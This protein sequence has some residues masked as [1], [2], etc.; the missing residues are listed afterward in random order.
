[1]GGGG[2]GGGPLK[3]VIKKAE[4]VGKVIFNPYGTAASMIAA[5]AGASG[6]AQ[7]AISFAGSS[8][9]GGNSGGYLSGETAGFAGKTFVDKPKELKAEAK[10]LGDATAEAQR[11]TLAELTQRD[12]QEKAEKDASSALEQAKARQRRKADKGR[13]STILTD[14]LGGAGGEENQGKKNLLGL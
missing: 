12:N 1:M 14:S 10:R 2:G 4:T 3:K 11:K 5:K 7:N 8:A 6:T 9:T 13:K